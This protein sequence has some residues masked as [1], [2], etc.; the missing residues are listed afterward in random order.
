MVEKNGITWSA[1]TGDYGM[2]GDGSGSLAL[3]SDMLKENLEPNELIFTTILSACS[4]TGMIGEGWRCFNLMCRDYNFVPSMKHYACMVDLLARAG[5]LEE[6]LDF[7]EN[8]PIQPE[9]CLFGFFLHGRFDLGEV[10][11]RI[12]M[13]LVTMY[14]C[15]LYASN[16]RWSQ[17]TRVSSLV[18][19]TIF[20]DTWNHIYL[21]VPSIPAKSFEAGYD[22]LMG[23]V[24]PGTS[25]S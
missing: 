6:A 7:I 25:A 17:V 13:K 15:N 24:E 3:F 2:Q 21:H 22:G 18:G 4:H 10:A 11:I 19:E 20:L 9:V 23:E 12:L 5:R 1:M 14:S 16:G 8:M